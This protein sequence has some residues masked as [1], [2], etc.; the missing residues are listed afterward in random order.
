MIK[1][2][3]GIVSH[4]GRVVAIETDVNVRIMSDVWADIT[5][6]MVYEPTGES[7][8]YA[9]G[10]GRKGLFRRIEIRNS[11]FPALGN[12]G[13]DA[14]IDASDDIKEVY[15]AWKRGHRFAKALRED[16]NLQY[17]IQE[18]RRCVEKGKWVRVTSGRKV[19]QGTEGIV[20]WVGDSQWGTKVGIALPKADGTFRMERKVGR[21]GKAYE[22]YADVQWTYTK[23]CSVLS[24]P[25]GRIL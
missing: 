23:N 8:E 24:G 21:N 14:E 15:K 6:A 11:E 25:G 5:Y 17:Q 13:T 18:R 22:T 16:E 7:T 1:L 9:Q 3:N 10:E 2:S 12:D 4:V 19:P 20:F